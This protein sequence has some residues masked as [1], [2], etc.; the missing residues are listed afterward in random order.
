MILHVSDYTGF[1]PNSKAEPGT[2]DHFV[3]IAPPWLSFWASYRPELLPQ[4]AT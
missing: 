1:Y 4:T 3:S 2:W